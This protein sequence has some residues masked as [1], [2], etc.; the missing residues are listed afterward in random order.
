MSHSSLALRDDAER[1]GEEVIR[2]KLRVESGRE[3]PVEQGIPDFIY[4]DEL[5]DSEAGAKASYDSVAEKN[6]R[7]FG[8]G[9]EPS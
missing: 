8:V 4:P 7:F 9:I 6:Q 5:C 2:G 1:D 3:Y